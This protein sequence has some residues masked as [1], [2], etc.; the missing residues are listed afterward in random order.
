MPVSTGI[1]RVYPSLRRLPC[2]KPART[3]LFCTISPQ[4][5]IEEE[6]LPNYNAADYYPVNI[7]QIFNSRYQVM[8]KLGF[9]SNS[10]MWLSR[11]LQEVH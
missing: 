8:G 4:A 1:R 5:K 6:R 2:V 11:D 10:T 9:G 7:G 3:R